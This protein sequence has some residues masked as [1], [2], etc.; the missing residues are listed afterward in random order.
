MVSPKG[1]NP[2]YLDSQERED[3][4]VIHIGPSFVK[5]TREE[6][7]DTFM[8]LFTSSLTGSARTWINKYPSGSFKTHEDLEQDFI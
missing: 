1:L 3:P 2:G 4:M 6:H 8:R 5:G 7:P